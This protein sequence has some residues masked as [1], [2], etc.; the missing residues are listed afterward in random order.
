MRIGI[1]ARFLTHSQRGGF[2]TYTENLVNALSLVDRTN[3]YVLYVDRPPA[4]ATLPKSDNFTCRVVDVKLPVI[5]MPVREQVVLRRRIA[6][7][8]LDIVHF[9]CNTAPV[10]M[11]GK[12]VV[13]LHDI[14]QLTNPQTFEY[15]TGLSACKRW[16]ISAYSRWT[17]LRTVQA[18]SKI[19]TVSSYEKEQMKEHLGIVPARIRVTH[20]APNALFVPASR[21]LKNRWRSRPKLPIEH[22]VWL[23]IL[24]DCYL[25]SVRVWITVLST[26][27]QKRA[28]HFCPARRIGR[29]PFNSQSVQ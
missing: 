11:R 12:F 16:L 13:T 27:Q 3:T 21:E 26:A 8:N 14:I 19:I 17:V 20:L 10:G 18:A 1:D 28:L 22:L 24:F 9:L 2:K 7:V 4:E 6:Q 15:I 5:G 29:S 23:T 25:P